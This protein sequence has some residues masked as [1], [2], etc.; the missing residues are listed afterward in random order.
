M[1]S[2]WRASQTLNSGNFPTTAQSFTTPTYRQPGFRVT[3]V[4][5]DNPTAVGHTFSIAA[6]DGTVL[7]SGTCSVADQDIPYDFNDAPVTWKDFQL[8]QISSGTL[9]IWYR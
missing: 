7:L 2:T 5:W 3:K 8:T 9:Y 6:T 1:G 4:L